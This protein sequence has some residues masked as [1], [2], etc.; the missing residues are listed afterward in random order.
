MFYVQIRHGNSMPLNMS[1]SLDVLK[2][3]G[4]KESA[5]NVDNSKTQPGNRHRR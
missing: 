1:S 2:G 5:E 4:N 3:S